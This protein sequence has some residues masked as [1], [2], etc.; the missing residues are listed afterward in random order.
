MSAIAALAR[1][2][3]LAGLLG[4]MPAVAAPELPA[5]YDP[6]DLSMPLPAPWRLAAAQDDAAPAPADKPLPAPA[7]QDAFGAYNWRGPQPAQ[8]DWSGIRRDTLYFL[9][10]QFGAVAVLYLAPDDVSG[11]SEEDKEDYSFDKWKENVSQPVVDNDKWWINYVTHPYWGAAYYIRARERGFD[12]SQSFWYSVLLS[13]LFEY[14]VEAFAEP[15][16]MQ[17]L[18][19]TPMLGS[20]IGEYLFSP[21]RERIRAKP[22][23]LDW[24]DKALLFATDP[25]GVLNAQVDSLLGVETTLQLQPIGLQTVASASG[26]GGE[27][28][29]SPRQL[30]RVAPVWGLNFQAEW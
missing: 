27:R 26:V 11:W 24:G 16:S 18:I 13:T 5:A 19:V 25:L 1:L 21:L 22:G 6:G 15:V 8:P 17:D 4:A 28:P 30:S 23:A 29:G 9:G 20:M 14:G 2:L 3:L 12:R 10:Y 7:A